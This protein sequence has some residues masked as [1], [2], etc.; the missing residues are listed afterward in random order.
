MIELVKISDKHKKSLMRILN[1][2]EVEQWLAG[3]PFPY[4]EKDADEFIEHCKTERNPLE[5]IFAIELEGVH[6]G[7]IGLHTT[8]DNA[9]WIGYYI[10]NLYWRKG[11]GLQAINKILHLAFNELN[12]RMVYAFTYEDNT[13]SNN[14]LLKVGFTEKL[15]P[16]VFTKNGKSH[17]SKYFFKDNINK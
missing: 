11:Y 3:P 17:N 8:S 1:M 13:A 7:G 14:L 2:K 15:N 16:K 4:T 9:G 10:D 5:Y 12:L 6:I